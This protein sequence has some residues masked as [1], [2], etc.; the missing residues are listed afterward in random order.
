MSGLNAEELIG[1]NG[2]LSVDRDRFS[3]LYE[4]CFDYYMPE[5]QSEGISSIITNEEEQPLDNAGKSASGKLAS[6]L[7]SNTVSMGDEFFGFR[8]NSK[9]DNNDEVTRAF[10]DASKECLKQMQSSNFALVAFEAIDYYTKLNTLVFYSEY[11]E[12]DGL[13]FYNFPITHCSIAEDHLGRVN[14][15]FREFQMTACQAYGRWGDD[16][17]PKLKEAYNDPSRRY[18]SFK[19]IHA[20]LDRD[21]RDMKSLQSKDLPIA[22]Y[23]VEVDNKHI[24]EE[25]GYNSFPYAV[26]RFYKASQSAYGRGPSFS[27]LP[28]MR[29]I[30]RLRSDIIDGIELKLQPPVFIPGGS[31]AEDVDLSPAAI[32]YYNAQTGRIEFYTPN[33]DLQYAG[34][35]R[36]NIREEVKENFFADLFMAL[37]GLNNMTATEV[38]ERVS[39][40]IQMIL[41]VVSRLYDEFFSP[42][43]E[44]VFDLLRENEV[45]ELP[46][47][48]V[49]TEFRVDYTTKLDNR[50]QSLEIQQVLTAIQQGHSI[51]TLVQEAPD[52]ANILNVDHAVKTVFKGNNV[53]TELLYSDE[54]IAERR[55]AEAEAQAQQMAQQQVME[56]IKAIDPLKAAE[57]GSMIESGET[58]APQ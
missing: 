11:R 3:R 31:D 53:D 15:V 10:A 44:R 49:E 21:K 29:E 48:M 13:V 47:N 26:A 56:K 7:F 42:A 37:E 6:G 25:G 36:R 16:C 40:K 41:P 27:S 52:L 9:L 30:C 35:H 58:G 55:E 23:Y 12:G 50:L 14:T 54:E 1:M 45:I 33:I 57:E 8:S 39:E 46:E 22:S 28:A 32:N 19:F 17:S 38:S 5:M 20:V 18:E 34:E 51:M 2:R 43:I 24:V 4:D